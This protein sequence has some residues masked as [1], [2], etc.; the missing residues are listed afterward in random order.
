MD[1]AHR[2]ASVATDATGFASFNPLYMRYTPDSKGR[3]V[4]QGGY[5]Y[6]VLMLG[7]CRQ[8]LRS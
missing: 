1:Q 2:G 4:G 8:C 5:G 7:M 3:F 6:K